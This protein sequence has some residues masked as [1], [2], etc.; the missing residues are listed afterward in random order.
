MTGTEVMFM[1]STLCQ[2]NAFKIHF[3]CVNSTC[4]HVSALGHVILTPSS[5]LHAADAVSHP[6]DWMIIV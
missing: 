2:A 5:M 3:H 1:M 4:R 6:N